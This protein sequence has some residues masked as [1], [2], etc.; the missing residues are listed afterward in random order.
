M[1]TGLSAVADLAPAAATDCSAVLAAG[2]SVQ[3]PVSTDDF[4]SLLVEGSE[5]DDSP[6]ATA[7]PVSV[8]NPWLALARAPES[9]PPAID[10]PSLQGGAV[11]APCLM[12]ALEARAVDTVAPD[13]T[14]SD[15]PVDIVAMQ[16]FSTIVSLPVHTHRT[17][18]P[19]DLYRRGAIDRVV[20][21]QV[22]ANEP[23][24]PMLAARLF[25][26]RSSAVPAAL[27]NQCMGLAT[28]HVSQIFGPLAFGDATAPTGPSAVVPHSEVGSGATQA[29]LLTEAAR[30]PEA[31]MVPTT[32]TG[33]PTA[34]QQKLIDAL[35]ERMSVQM[36]QGMRQAV[37]RLEP[38][39]NG[40]IRI[41]LRQNVNG[42]AVHLS[43]THPE[44]VLQLQAIGESLRQDLCARHGGDVTVQVSAGRQGQGEAGGSGGREHASR[45]D[46]PTR[47]PGG[48]LASAGGDSSF[49]LAAC[50][51]AYVKRATA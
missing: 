38:G 46:A 43:A 9:E 34:R 18:Q 5:L 30:A 31:A 26:H 22:D 36:A 33:A 29:E 47:G 50:E 48:G 51:L 23:V 49:E 39:S 42:M 24:A 3:R 7:D 17:A 37:I 20:L 32:A 15:T 13:R 27:L 40:S 41:E 1:M 35:G 44:V 16:R 12:Q 14:T 4:E 2:L 19:V 11:A 28:T 8:L 6:D 45:D 21:P 25:N 10:M